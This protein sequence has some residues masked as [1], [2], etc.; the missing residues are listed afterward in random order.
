MAEAEGPEGPE[1][2][3]VGGRVDWA[4]GWA[5]QSGAPGGCQWYKI[6]TDF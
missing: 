3:A 6:R 2:E 5:G 4:G 1:A